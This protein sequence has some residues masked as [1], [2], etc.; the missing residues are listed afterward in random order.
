[1]EEME[2]KPSKLKIASMVFGLVFLVA[3]V[4]GFTFALFKFSDIGNEEN[5]IDTGTLVMK[6]DDDA[7]D[8]ISIENAYPVSDED[9]MKT[10]PY[11]FT[12]ENNGTLTAKYR[13]RLVKDPTLY[14]NGIENADSSHI[15]YG[16]QK[17]DGDMVI[18]LID[19][20]EGILITDEVLTS[21]HSETYSIRLWIDSEEDIDG[22]LF[23]TKTLEFH[24]RV[25]LEA[26][27]NGRTDYETG[28]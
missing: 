21:Q 14:P 6:I 11:K 28:K 10:D 5:I 18:G 23:E 4:I 8:V 17:G 7:S 22:S 24:G 19:E 26:I 25:Q 15:K 20:T 16:F 9:G 27:H 12:V 13:L 1:M 3:L 2:K